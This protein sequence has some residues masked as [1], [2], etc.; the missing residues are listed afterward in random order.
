MAAQARA[1]AQSAPDEQLLPRQLK[2]VVYARLRQQI[3]DFD[4]QPGDPLKEAELAKRLGVSKTPVREALLRLHEDRLVQIA[5]YKGA[6]VAGYSREDLMHIYGLREL[7]EG[8]CARD[9]AQSATADA[10]TEL[11]RVVRDTL[12]AVEDGEEHAAPDLL[13]AF[14]EIVY[15]QT[16]NPYIASLITNLHAHLQRIGQL[17]VRIPGRFSR[18]AVQHQAIYEA[19]VHHDAEGAERRMREHVISVMADQL[20]NF[21]ENDRP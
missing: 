15:R 18:S 2:D 12:Q 19:I 21:T 1:A 17:T 5:P 11:G 20:A 8:A 9:A 6:V 14:D 4:Y 13:S 16:R 10:L 3:I 7:L